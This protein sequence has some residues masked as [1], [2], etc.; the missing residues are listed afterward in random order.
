MSAPEYR[1]L[2]INLILNNDGYLIVPGMWGG[3][4]QPESSVILSKLT[5]IGN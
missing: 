2:G 4:C 1:L 5:D 3:L